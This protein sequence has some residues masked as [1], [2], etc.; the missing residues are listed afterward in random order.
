[1][2]A[3]RGWTGAQWQSLYALW[4][5][6]SG[7]NPRA[8]NPTSTAYGIPQ[9]LASTARQYGIG[10]REPSAARQIAAGLRYISDRYGTPAN[11]YG[12]WRNRSPHWYGSGGEITE[13]VLG[14]GLKTGRRYGFGERGPETVIPG[15]V[16]ATRGGQTVVNININ[17]GVYVSK[18]DIGAAV[19]DAL[20]AFRASGGRL[21]S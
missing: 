10:A 3:A 18:R 5:G 9:F 2:A 19:N 13:K 8:D 11:A 15:R 1:M 20:A 14:V 16:R 4:Q 17:G 21:A 12:A 6:E 7:W